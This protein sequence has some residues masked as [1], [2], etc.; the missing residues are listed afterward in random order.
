[1]ARDLLAGID[2]DERRVWVFPSPVTRRNHIVNVNK[3]VKTIRRLTGIDFQPHDLRRTAA[4]YMASFGVPRPTIGKVLNHA[5]AGIT[6]VYDRHSYDRQ[7]QQALEA[8]GRR[9]EQIVL[10]EKQAPDNV[11]E[12]TSA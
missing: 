3:A 6:K 10:G 2:R 5:D 11:V 4:S 9:L 8:W 7:K 12:L 1:M